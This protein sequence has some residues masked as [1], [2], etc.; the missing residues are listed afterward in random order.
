MLV[1]GDLLG[2]TWVGVL[3]H[4]ESTRGSTFLDV[5]PVLLHISSGSNTTI[6]ETHL[7]PTYSDGHVIVVKPS[8]EVMSNGPANVTQHADCG[9]LLTKLCRISTLLVG[10]D[11][12]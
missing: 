12:V 4:Q 5:V 2:S 8:A 7:F 10:R 1:L 6:G 3:R 11:K 9:N